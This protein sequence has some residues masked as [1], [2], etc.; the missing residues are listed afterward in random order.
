MTLCSLWV[1]FIIIQWHVA[2]VGHTHDPSQ[3][4][5][6]ILGRAV[7]DSLVKTKKEWKVSIAEFMLGLILRFRLYFGVLKH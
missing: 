5:S 7:K 2:T 4:K 1:L 6:D 3:G